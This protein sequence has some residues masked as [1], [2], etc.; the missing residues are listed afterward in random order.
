MSR[1][2]LLSVISQGMTEKIKK[3]VLEITMAS[4]YLIIVKDL[5][6]IFIKLRELLVSPKVIF[7]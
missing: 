5:F 6:E 7:S 3:S 1:V 2:K 4:S